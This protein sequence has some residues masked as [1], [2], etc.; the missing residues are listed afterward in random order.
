MFSIVLGNSCNCL[1]GQPTIDDEQ[2]YYKPNLGIKYSKQTPKGYNFRRS[3]AGLEATRV[4]EEYEEESTNSMCDFFPGFLAIGTLGSSDQQISSPSSTPTFPISV[5]SITEKE[6]EV[7]ENDLK[8]INDELEKVLG[9][10]TKDDVSYDSSSRNSHVSTG[11]SSHVSI[12][13]LSGKPIEEGIELNGNNG[14]AICPLKGYLFGTAIELPE[15]TTTAANKKE[16]RTSLGELFQRSKLAEEN[17]SGKCDK[18]EDRRNEREADKSAMNLMK[19]KLKK[20]MFHACSKNSTTSINGGPID[21]AAAAE[22]KLNKV[23]IHV[24][25]LIKHNFQFS[26]LF[27]LT[28]TNVTHINVLCCIC[29]HGSLAPTSH[30]RNCFMESLRIWVGPHCQH[31]WV[32]CMD[33][34]GRRGQMDLR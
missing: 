29:G 34:N 25:K 32:W 13:T 5:E 10:E 20:R 3:F 6:D 19:E 23:H 24:L 18:L 27:I 30:N 8:L 2:I 31:Y 14:N 11:R 12:I 22:T 28:S 1:S 4:D 7:T 16:H 9:A 33:N 17:F 21:S 15:T 26:L